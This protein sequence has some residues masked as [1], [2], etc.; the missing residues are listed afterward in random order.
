MNENKVERGITL[1]ALIITIII[2]LILAVVTIGSMKNSNIITYAQNAANDYE[3]GKDKEK[4]ILSQYETILD[5]QQGI[6]PWKLQEDGITIKNGKTREIKTIGDTIENDVVLAA[7]GG[8]KNTYIKPW[9]IIGVENGRLKL[10]STGSVRWVELGKNDES[11]YKKDERG[12]PTTELKDEFKN[13]IKDI[14]NQ[15]GETANLELE[16]AMWSYNHLEETLDDAAKTWTGIPSARSINIKDLEAIFDI[17]EDANNGRI[18]KYYFEGDG[19]TGKIYSRYL[20]EGKEDKEENWSEKD[21]G[22]YDVFVNYDGR[23]IDKGNVE[24]IF[25]FKHTNYYSTTSEEEKIKFSALIPDGYSNSK[26]MYWVASQSIYCADSKVHFD[27][28]AFDSKGL[29]NQVMFV[30][31]GEAGGN[32]LSVRAI[33]YI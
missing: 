32:I 13:K 2:L 12:N 17:K 16:I 11:V 19:D 29:I 23:M 9:A 1:I 31:N 30:S 8:T 27:T 4:G 22:F 14:Y 25:K 5:E 7:T 10:V 15:D 24:P 28:Y 20:E 6:G 18:Y 33:V 26:P 3:T 21:G